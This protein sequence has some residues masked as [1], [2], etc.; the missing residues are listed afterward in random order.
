MKSRRSPEEEALHRA[1]GE[2]LHYI[3]D[4]IGVAGSPH[5]R[6]EYDG[7]VDTVC[8]L[9]W[10]GAQAGVLAEHLERAAS[11][12][13][14]LTGSGERAGLAAAALVAWRAAVTRQPA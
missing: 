9:L 14:G 2:V 12:G 3:W 11:E 7:Y 4:P 10:D 5:A 6:D 13:M 8:S 1:V